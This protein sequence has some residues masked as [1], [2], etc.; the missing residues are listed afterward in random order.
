[1]IGQSSLLFVLIRCHLCPRRALVRA[2]ALDKIKGRV[3][4]LLVSIGA[5]GL[6]P[7]D[8]QPF[9]EDGNFLAPYVEQQARATVSGVHTTVNYSNFDQIDRN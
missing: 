1:M 4:H 7:V 2:G 5:D 9:P 8:H 3:H 6:Y